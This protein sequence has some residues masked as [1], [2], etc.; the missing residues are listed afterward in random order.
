MNL[1]Y[2]ESIYCPVLHACCAIVN[3]LST[4]HPPYVFEAWPSAATNEATPKRIVDLSVFPKK[5]KMYGAAI[6]ALM[7]CSVQAIHY[8]EEKF[9]LFLFF[10]IKLHRNFQNYDKD[11]IE[12]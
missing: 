3:V 5:S 2:S 11:C 10:E 8:L 12:L 6:F 1:M 9:F 4:T 7:L